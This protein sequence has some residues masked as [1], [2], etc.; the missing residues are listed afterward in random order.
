MEFIF[1]S[2]PMKYIDGIPAYKFGEWPGIK[3][4]KFQ[5]TRRIIQPITQKNI[6]NSIHNQVTPI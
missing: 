3:S 6:F 2:A 4:C 1:P 5:P